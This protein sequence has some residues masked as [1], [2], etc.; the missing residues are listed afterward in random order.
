MKNSKNTSTSS[1]LEMSNTVQLQT[2]DN[3]LRDLLKNHHHLGTG[4]NTMVFLL[5]KTKEI[6]EAAGH[7]Q[8]LHA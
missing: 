4:E 8:Q 3:Q 7:S 6:V 5:L 1:L 2:K